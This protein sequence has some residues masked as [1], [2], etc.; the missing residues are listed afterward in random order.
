MNSKII[1]LLE[2]N[3]PSSCN[4]SSKF[5]KFKF[6]SASYSE[7][8]FQKYRENVIA[9]RVSNRQGRYY[10][11]EINFGPDDS[12]IWVTYQPLSNHSKFLLG[13]DVSTG[14]PFD[15]IDDDYGGS[16]T[17]VHSRKTLFRK[18]LSRLKMTSLKIKSRMRLFPRFISKRE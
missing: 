15:I 7:Q 16:L 11:D 9:E 14:A 4:R 8:R 5:Q 2:Q 1:I 13:H 18:R 10:V 12:I 17:Q 3:L 6:Q